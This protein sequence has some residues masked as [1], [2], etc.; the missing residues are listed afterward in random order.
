MKD[1][2]SREIG[3][4]SE[5]MYQKLLDTTI[6]LFGLGGVGGY[7]LEGLIRAGVEKFILIDK[8]RFEISNINRQLAA[9][10]NVIGKFKTNVYTDRAENI[11]ENCDIK[12]INEKI[13]KDNLS[14]LLSQYDLS[15]NIYF[16]DCIDDLD[17]KVAIVKYCNDNSIRLISS[18]GTA[19]HLSS[20]NI[21]ISDITKTKYCPVAKIIRKK[22]KDINIDK[23]TCLYI[24]E[25]IARHDKP[26]LSTI[27]YMPA[28]C[29]LKIAEYVIKEI[30]M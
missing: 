20:T 18:M 9:T 29:G 19:N 15:D 16:I 17:A 24:D 2:F 23:L 11:N 27:S 4:I 14:S 26:Y 30:T 13:S 22:L 10:K 5:E 6:V 7:V 8:D 12:V 1:E 28:I 3:L 21:K 25:E